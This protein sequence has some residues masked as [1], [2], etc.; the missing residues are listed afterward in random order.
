MYIVK[1]SGMLNIRLNEV[2]NLASIVLFILTL[3]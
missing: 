3:L 1:Y 2:L